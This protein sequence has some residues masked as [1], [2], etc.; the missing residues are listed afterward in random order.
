MLNIRV[1]LPCENQIQPHIKSMT[2]FQIPKQSGVII[3]PNTITFPHGAL[4][5]HIFEP[6][7]VKMLEDALEKNSMICVANCL[8]QETT[9]P[10]EYTAKT[11]TI[12]LIRIAKKTEAGNSDLLLHSIC[13]VEF[14]SWEEN[15]AQIHPK[16]YPIANIKPIHNI[17]QP[18]TESTEL[19][20]KSLRDATSRFLQPL[21]ADS[22]S[23][24]N[25]TLNP[26]SADLATLT[27]LIAQQF[28]TDPLLRQSLLEEN[29]PTKRAETLIRQLR[30]RQILL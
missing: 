23:K 19:V 17:V 12:G 15:S 30:I 8:S 20:I 10:S 5:L 2:S 28:I 22:I 18:V 25:E 7:Y 13:R 26:V 14:L 24:F 9:N 4:P 11:G 1:I 6:R 3:L 29:N 27:D 21:P 16:S